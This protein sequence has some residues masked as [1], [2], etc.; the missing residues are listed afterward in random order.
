MKIFWSRLADEMNWGMDGWHQI[1]RGAG[2]MRVRGPEQYKTSLL[3]HHGKCVHF[4]LHLAALLLVKHS[5]CFALCK[6]LSLGVSFQHHPFS[7]GDTCCRHLYTFSLSQKPI[8]G[9]HVHQ[10]WFIRFQSASYELF[11]II[12]FIQE[13]SQPSNIGSIQ[14]KCS[15]FSQCFAMLY[16]RRQIC[17]N[18]V[19]KVILKCN[20]FIILLFYLKVL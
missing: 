18:N 3:W 7:T 2:G 10:R 16:N 15:L 17:R 6:G 14:N 5:S 4:T 9:L 8:R 12:S 20:S 19:D 13:T 1:K 11:G